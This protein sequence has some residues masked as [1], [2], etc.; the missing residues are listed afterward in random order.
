MKNILSTMMQSN[1]WSTLVFIFIV[2]I[3]LLLFEQLI[4]LNIFIY[5]F[6]LL[7][8]FVFM[9]INTIYHLF[10]KQWLKAVFT[11]TL[12][13]IAGACI[14]IS[15]TMSFLIETLDGDHWADHL[16]LPKNVELNRPIDLVMEDQRP[17]SLLNIEKTTMDFQLYNSF[18]PGLYT[19]DFWYG[20]TEPGTIYLKA[21][22]ITQ[23]SALSQDRLPEQSKIKIQNATSKLVKASLSH[24]FTIYEGDWGKPY[25]ARFEVWFIPSNG[26]AERKLFTKNYIIE[27]WQR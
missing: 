20:N 2:T 16:A 8:S 9:A 17:D 27:G 10:N 6:L 24:I 5:G 19:Y 18:Q 15:I 4:T 21:F 13:M 11:G 12:F 26:G 23:E 22:E 7:F 3:T 14:V 1:K 25:G